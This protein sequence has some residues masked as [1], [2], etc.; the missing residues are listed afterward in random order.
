MYCYHFLLVVYQV[1]LKKLICWKAIT[2]LFIF[3]CCS[4]R[5]VSLVI[6]TRVGNSQRIKDNLQAMNLE[7]KLFKETWSIFAVLFSKRFL[8]WKLNTLM[9]IKNAHN[10]C[11]IMFSLY[12]TTAQIKMLFS[13]YW[14]PKPQNILPRRK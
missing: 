7:L 6:V 5:R 9:F 13:A 11:G 2:F 12:K 14:D 3:G 8:F 10:N 4:A 1:W